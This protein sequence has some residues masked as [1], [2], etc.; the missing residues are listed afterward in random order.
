MSMKPPNIEPVVVETEN[1]TENSPSQLKLLI[2]RGKEQ[3]YLTY[4]DVHDNLP[5]HVVE[6][7]EIEEFIHRIE[8][9]G[10]RVYESA[11]EA[12]QLL[13]SDEVSGDDGDDGSGGIS[14]D[15]SD[16]NY[17]T[18]DPVRMY[19]REMGTVELLTRQGEIVIAKRIEEEMS[20]PGQIKVS[21]IREK[22]AVEYA[23]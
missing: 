5:S 6:A 1:P 15:E 18:S 10:I 17:R 12:D 2:T 16:L 3:G 13:L 21:V 7:E 8:D 9:M 22:R 11:P 19:M 14:I 20:F 4:S 23:R